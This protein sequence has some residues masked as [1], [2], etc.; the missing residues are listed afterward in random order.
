M[1]AST[2]FIVAAWL[3]AS[4]MAAVVCWMALTRVREEN[5]ALAARIQSANSDAESRPGNNQSENEEVARLRR[6]NQGL[7]RLRSE[8]SQLQSLKPELER[9]RAENQQLREII[10]SDSNRVQAEWA[11]WVL[12]VR[13]NGVKLEDVPYLIQAL[14][15]EA[16]AVRV[17]ATKALRNIGLQRLLDTNLTPQ[18]EM[19]LRTAAKTAVPG[20][21]AAL[22]DPDVMVRANAA[23]TLGFLREQPDI[24]VPALMQAL[25]DQ[26]NRV[27]L[28]AA[29]ALGRLQAD[30]SGAIPALSQMAQSPDA[31]RRAAAIAVLG[32]IHP[33]SVRKAG[34]Q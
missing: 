7:L 26:E 11:S 5:R 10:G 16:T 32:Q 15:N 30:G 19:E 3:V 1:K 28:S 4:S 2:K 29:K 12:T 8:V 17:E 27:A 24:T 9:L 22:K 25:N 14:T 21:A 13:T 23:I 34:L 31:E 18:A 6:E 20:L 33:E